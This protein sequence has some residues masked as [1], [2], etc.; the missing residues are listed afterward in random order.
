MRL[1]GLVLVVVGVLVLG[2]QWFGGMGRAEA[3][4]EPAAAG[5]ADREGGWASPVVGGIAVVGG[6]LLLVGD[7]RRD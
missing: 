2:A 7:G 6:L 5:P 3:G 4:G 1:V